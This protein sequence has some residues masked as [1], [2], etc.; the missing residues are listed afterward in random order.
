MRGAEFTYCQIIICFQQTLLLPEICTMW[1]ERGEDSSCNMFPLLAVC[2][3]YYRERK[4]K[5]SICDHMS[6]VC[7]SLWLPGNI[8]CLISKLGDFG[9]F[10]FLDHQCHSL[11]IHKFLQRTCFETERLCGIM[12]KV[13]AL[14]SGRTGF[15]AWLPFSSYV[16]ARVAQSHKHVHALLFIFGKVT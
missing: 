12:G 6:N 14:K 11:L 9:K 13:L 3:G 7:P 10:Y 2:Q 5:T 16:Y 8:L 1:F 15:E 4:R